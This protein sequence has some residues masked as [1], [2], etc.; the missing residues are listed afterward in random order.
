[1]TSASLL[2]DVL[3]PHALGISDDKLNTKLAAMSLRN[4]PPARSR[5]LDDS[6]DEIVG[7]VSVFSLFCFGNILPRL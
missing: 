6:D 1:M 2:Q 7:V 4:S 3:R 5:T